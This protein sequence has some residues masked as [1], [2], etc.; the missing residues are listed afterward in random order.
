MSRYEVWSTHVSFDKE[1]PV[2]ARD[3]LETTRTD[4]KVAEEDRNIVA[5]ILHRK[6]WINEVEK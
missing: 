4:R 1:N 3:V 5:D 2:P 6:A